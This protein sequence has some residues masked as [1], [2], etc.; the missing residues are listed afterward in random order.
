[1]IKNYLLTAL[2]NL[3]RHKVF[4]FIHVFGLSIGLAC[5]MLIFLYTKDEVSFD[6]FHEKKNVFS[7]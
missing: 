5:C 7:G 3:L 2:R 4:S 1:M 6:R